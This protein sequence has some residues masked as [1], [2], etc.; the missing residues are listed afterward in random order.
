MRHLRS[1]DT[2]ATSAAMGTQFPEA[3]V[4]GRDSVV[5]DIDSEAVVCGALAWSADGDSS[6]GSGGESE[7]DEELHFD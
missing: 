1:N 4:A 2:R 6:R 7:E 5:R 3:A